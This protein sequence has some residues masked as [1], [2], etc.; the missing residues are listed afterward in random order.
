MIRSFFDMGFRPSIQVPVS[1]RMGFSLND[2]E[3][4]W[5]EHYGEWKSATGGLTAPTKPGQPKPGYTPPPS[6]GTSWLLI[7]GAAALA[8]GVVIAIVASQRTK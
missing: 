8:V 1:P 3:S 7:G 4:W 6:G 2:M 5:K